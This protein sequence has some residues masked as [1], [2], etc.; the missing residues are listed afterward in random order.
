MG[1]QCSNDPAP[2][3]LFREGSSGQAPPQSYPGLEMGL[4]E[5]L[6]SPQRPGRVLAVDDNAFNLQV[7]S[8]QVKTQPF[9]LTTAESPERALELCASEPFEAILSDVSMPG[10][11]GLELCRRI[12][13]T[14]N[15][16]T[17]LVFLSAVRADD[18]AVAQWMD[19]GA[20]DYLP[21][22]CPLPELVAKLRVMVRLSRQQEALAQTQRQEALMEV[23]GGAAHELSQ[24]LAAARL[25]LDR[26]ER[27]REHP[28]PEQ[29][30]Q[31]R[32][33]VDR[34]AS[35]L[36]QIRGLR[37]YVTK[38][39]PASGPILDLKKSREISGAHAGLK[40]AKPEG[41]E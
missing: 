39:Y 41:S 12:R 5:F 3:T 19:A 6:P 27:Q 36:D 21:K 8:L 38:P 17:P 7:L 24:P 9:I 22:P 20:L 28:S 18:T 16:R 2:P 34:T 29:M 30:S 23:A 15:S 14:L 35:I 13:R 33:F 31:L 32:D 10:M 37:V 4:Q 11:D 40:T 1:A 25:L 26:L